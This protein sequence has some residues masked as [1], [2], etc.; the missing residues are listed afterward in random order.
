MEKEDEIEVCGY[1]IDKD[2]HTM[3]HAF[4]NYKK[5]YSTFLVYTIP[6]AMGQSGSPIIKKK[7]GEWFVVGI[8]LG[9]LSTLN[10]NLG[11]RLTTRRV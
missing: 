3:W 7:D 11:L 4:G 10:G 5:K 8:H 9:E 1:P 2:R 6:T